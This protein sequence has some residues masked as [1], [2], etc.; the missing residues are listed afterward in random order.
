MSSMKPRALRPRS[1]TQ[2]G[3]SNGRLRAVFG[4]FVPPSVNRQ[5]QTVHSGGGARG[6]E[7]M[8]S[9]EVD[10]DSFMREQELAV[11]DKPA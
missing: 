9:R 6:R 8:S 3:N 2:S 4:V 1:Q 10:H 11:R 5:W 7:R